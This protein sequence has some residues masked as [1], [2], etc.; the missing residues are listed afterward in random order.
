M[1]NDPEL[2]GKYLGTITRDF[3]IVC[4]TLKEAS[5]QLRVRKISQYPI[6]AM[7][8]GEISLGKLFL[9]K[10]EVFTD[11]NY[12][13]SFLED[14]TTRNLID[15]EAVEGFKENYKDPDEFCCIFVVDNEFNKYVFILYLKLKI[16]TTKKLLR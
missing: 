8:K 6:F 13:F 16:S 2:S 12:Y 11:F 15:G 3:A 9:A 10:H 4:D 1:E 5:Y 7:T 14:F